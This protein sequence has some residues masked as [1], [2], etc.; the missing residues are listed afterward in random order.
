MALPSSTCET[1][2]MINKDKEIYGPLNIMKTIYI[3][4]RMKIRPNRSILKYLY[5][6]NANRGKENVNGILTKHLY[7]KIAQKYT[8]KYNKTLVYE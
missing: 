2:N 1:K 5:M 4:T 6:N 8:T 7:E 3:Y